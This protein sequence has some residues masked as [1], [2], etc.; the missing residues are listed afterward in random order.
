MKI[1]GSIVILVTLLTVMIAIFSYQ[2]FTRTTMK[3]IT[4]YVR[5]VADFAST[6]VLKWD[7]QD[8]LNMGY[9]RILELD[10]RDG[11]DMKAVI[12]VDGIIKKTEKEAFFKMCCAF[13]IHW[14][15]Q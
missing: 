13:V 2:I 5:Q 6:V 7:F 11:Y 9:D 15:V 3:E 8:Y 10:G 12:K 1:I 14:M 4:T